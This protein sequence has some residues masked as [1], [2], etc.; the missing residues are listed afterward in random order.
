MSS[1]DLEKSTK[2]PLFLSLLKHQKKARRHTIFQTTA[3]PLLPEDHKQA[4]KLNT[5][6]GI[7]QDI[8]KRPKMALHNA[9][10]TSQ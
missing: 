5:C 1:E 10:A 2:H 3:L 7:T 4:N 9:E 8:P 6:L